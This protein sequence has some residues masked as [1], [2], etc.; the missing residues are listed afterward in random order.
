M[1]N[2]IELSDICAGLCALDSPNLSKL[3]REIGRI[4][5][6]RSSSQALPGERPANV[7][8]TWSAGDAAEDCAVATFYVGQQVSFQLPP[9]MKTIIGKVR[10]VQRARLFIDA[11]GNSENDIL[12]V[13]LSPLLVSLLP[14]IVR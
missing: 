8:E 2:S 11:A 14:P 3:A 1:T 5:V 10:R 13:S 12:R 7:N 6:Q 4:M 9:T